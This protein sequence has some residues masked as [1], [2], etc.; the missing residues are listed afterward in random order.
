M[1]VECPNRCVW[2]LKPLSK[3]LII[4]LISDQCDGLLTDQCEAVGCMHLHRLARFA[5]DLLRHVRG[6]GVRHHRRAH[7]RAPGASHREQLLHVLLAHAR[8]RQAP[9]A[10]APRAACR[11]AASE[12]SGPGRWAGRGP[13][14]RGRVT[15]ER[16]NGDRRRRDGRRDRL[17]H[18]TRALQYASFGP[19][20]SFPNRHSP[21]NYLLVL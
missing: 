21:R 3:A 20:G 10:A 14:G 15:G 12:G 4:C 18:K 11:G 16:E 19:A 17:R 1:S 13:E 8:A 2:L 6:R 9:E 5:Q 7:D